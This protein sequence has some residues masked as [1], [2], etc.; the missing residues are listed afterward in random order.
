MHAPP[1]PRAEPEE[2]K[3]LGDGE[4]VSAELRASAE[5]AYGASLA[6]VRVHTGPLADAHVRGHGALATAEGDRI[7]LASSVRPGTLTGDAILAHELAHVVQQG[8]RQDGGGATAETAP[9]GPAGAEHE[10]HRAAAAVLAR[11][12]RHHDEI[13][14]RGIDPQPVAAQ[15]APPLT[16]GLGL[17]LQRCGEDPEWASSRTGEAPT[18]PSPTYAGSRQETVDDLG[19]FDIVHG[20][21]GARHAIIDGDGD[22]SAELDLTLR[23][24]PGSTFSDPQTIDVTAQRLS[25]TTEHANLTTQPIT[26][27]FDISGGRTFDNSLS[28]KLVQRTDGHQPTEIQAT[29]SV[30]QAFASMFIAPPSPDGPRADYQVTIDLADDYGNRHR[31]LAPQ[32]FSFPRDPADVFPVFLPGTPQQAGSVW[33]LDITMGRFADNYRLTFYKPEQTSNRVRMGVSPLAGGEAAGTEAIDVETVGPLDV[34]V[35]SARGPELAIDL[36]GDGRPDIRLFEQVTPTTNYEYGATQRGP[37]NQ[38]R[39]VLTV[40]DGTGARTYGRSQREVRQGNYT[41]EGQNLTDEMD[42]IS[43]AATPEGLSL[44]AQVPDLATDV[45]RQQ[46]VLTSLRR[47][48]A[49]AGVFSATA[50]QSFDHLIDTYL[51]ALAAPES[52]RQ[53]ALEAAHAAALAFDATWTAETA[54]ATHETHQHARGDTFDSV[55][56]QYTGYVSADFTNTERV[57]KRIADA[58]A[59]HDLVGAGRLIKDLGQRVASWVGAR[60]RARGMTEQADRIEGLQQ[61]SALQDQL[62]DKPG[63]KRAIAVFH[64][65][66]EFIRTGSPGNVPLRLYYW[67]EGSQWMLQDLTYPSRPDSIGVL[68][69]PFTAGQTEPPPELFDQL[70]DKQR[71]PKGMIQYVLAGPTGRSGVVRTTEPWEIEDV[72]SWI[73]LGLAGAALLAGAVLTGGAAAVVVPMLWGLSATAGVVGAVAGMVHASDQGRLTGGRI[74]LGLAQ[75]VGSLAG[76]AAAG[77]KTV[78][79]ARMLLAGEAL[80]AAGAVG[81]VTPFA[82]SLRVLT[83]AQVGADSVQV[84]LSGQE[85]VHTLSNIANSA[86]SDGDKLRAYA[87]AIGQFG[88]TTGLSYVGIRGNLHELDTALNSARPRFIQAGG[89]V[90]VPGRATAAEYEAELQRHLGATGERNPVRVVLVDPDQIGSSIG[91]TRVTRV[92]GHWQVEV[93]DGIHPSA[94]REEAIHL[95]QLALADQSVG[96]V[97]AMAGG[98]RAAEAQLLRTRQAAQTFTDVSGRWATASPVER[99]RAHEARLDL[100]IDGQRRLISRLQADVANPPAQGAASPE[101]TAALIDNAYQT[102]DNLQIRRAELVPVRARVESEHPTHLGDVDPQLDTRPDLFAKR[103][104]PSS[105]VPPAW[106]T[107]SQEDFIRSYKARYPESSLDDADL[108]QRYLLR[109]RLNPDTGRLV[110]ISQDR[111]EVAARYRG[112]EER[113]HPS[114]SDRINISEADRNRTSALLAERDA[115]RRERDLAKSRIPPDTEAANRALYRMVDASRQI[116]EHAASMWVNR[117]YPGPPRPALRYPSGTA[118]SR[119]GDFDQIW[120]CRRGDQTIWVVVEAKGGASDLGSRRVAGPTGPGS[121]PRAEQGSTPYFADILT[122]MQRTPGLGRKVASQVETAARTAPGSVHYM[123]VS[124]PIES[125]PAASGT[126]LSSQ[127]NDISIREFDITPAATTPTTTTTV[128]P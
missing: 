26:R 103:L 52:G 105:E 117:A 28:P 73:A 22:Q 93:V 71:F 3:R 42:V 41:A 68:R 122:N 31:Q 36:N 23:P 51:A 80:E 125:V 87:L 88:V 27:S 82:S 97:R 98:D 10:A 79:A 96:Q 90:L 37:G 113:M 123:H 48:A 64:S 19:M 24:G 127:L 75:I 56:N 107:L 2:R 16:R 92:G 39:L 50:S 67:K 5:A 115:A 29:G 69:A 33:A 95:E 109:R 47:E 119:S 14:A 18:T 6:G 116:G 49:T 9:P 20:G 128:T 102:L 32:S 74:V 114:G 60:Y 121:G 100:E 17:R 99:L 81:R 25:N 101:V 65:A 40:T 84:V 55:S 8:A 91:M 34:R 7:A 120:E 77:L 53:Q 62:V 110:D 44:A 94:M 78:T 54:S 104:V 86:M 106:Y 66:P 83:M 1:T 118:V 108:A 126:G 4:P 13:R 70:N 45:I 89:E 46:A 76:G 59:A 30:G 72:A 57:A 21:G 111:V 124:A 58:L 11:S 35:V 85:L 12:G 112:T 43:A 63:L 15:G 38:R 61:L